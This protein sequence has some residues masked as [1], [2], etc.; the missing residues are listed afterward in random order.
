M[1]ENKEIKGKNLRQ[2]KIKKENLLIAR[3]KKTLLHKMNL[4]RH[5]LAV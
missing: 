1:W 4:F 3:K 2:V 5:R